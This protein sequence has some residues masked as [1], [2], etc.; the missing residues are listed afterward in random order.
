MGNRLFIFKKQLPTLNQIVRCITL[1]LNV[2][3]GQRSTLF[4]FNISL[5]T[6]Q[7]KTLFRKS[8]SS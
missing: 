5:T 3:H 8:I 7:K 6:Y 4:H 1:H 2:L